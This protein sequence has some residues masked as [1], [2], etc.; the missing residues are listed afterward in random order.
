MFVKRHFHEML[1][2]DVPFHRYYSIEDYTNKE[3]PVFS[4]CKKKKKIIRDN[5]HMILTSRF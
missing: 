2:H 4:K 1:Q 5:E 3:M